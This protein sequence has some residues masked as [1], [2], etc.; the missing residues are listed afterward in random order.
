[1]LTPTGFAEKSRLTLERLSGALTLLSDSRCDFAAV[2]ARAKERGWSTVVIVSA[3][4][5]AEICTICAL[6]RGI[7]VIAIVD[8]DSGETHMLGLPVWPA[9]EAVDE[10][11]DGAVM[12][13]LRDPVG[14]RDWALAALG[15]NRVLTPTFLSPPPRQEAA[16]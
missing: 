3:S 16:Q 15:A 11:F 13:D 9:F 2:F 5:L 7:R 10:V 8:P 4:Q 14:R 12:A 6:E 1:M